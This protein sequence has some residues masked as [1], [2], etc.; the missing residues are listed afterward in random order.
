MPKVRHPALQRFGG[1]IRRER[2]RQGI[3]QEQLALLSEVDR[4]YMGLV[5]RGQEN[6]SLLTILKICAT[7][8]AKPSVLLDRAGL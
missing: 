5:E 7:L 8:D 6:I 4:G 2:E 1:A 3:S